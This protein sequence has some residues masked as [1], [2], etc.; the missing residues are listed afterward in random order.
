MMFSNSC[1]TDSWNFA[2][3]HTIGTKKYVV[4]ITVA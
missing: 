1:Y 2:G 3:D 4:P